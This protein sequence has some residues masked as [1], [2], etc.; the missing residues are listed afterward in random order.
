VSQRPRLLDT[1]FAQC[2][3]RRVDRLGAPPPVVSRLWVHV[4]LPTAFSRLLGFAQVSRQRDTGLRTVGQTKSGMILRIS[5]SSKP[6]RGRDDLS[7]HLAVP[8]SLKHP[9]L[10]MAWAEAACV[11][12]RHH[13]SRRFGDLFRP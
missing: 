13:H 5:T 3:E 8:A 7:K 6:V 4:R 10:Y 11:R 9:R 1:T 2:S 12:G